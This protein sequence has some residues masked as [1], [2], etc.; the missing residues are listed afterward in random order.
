MPEG[1]VVMRRKAPT[2]DGHEGFAL[3]NPSGSTR[4]RWKHKAVPPHASPL[5][6]SSAPKTTNSGSGEATTSDGP[7]WPRFLQRKVV[8]L[9]PATADGAQGAGTPTP[10]IPF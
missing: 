10:C 8:G 3:G 9:D 4:R 5:A 2:G 6:L 1:V 7:A